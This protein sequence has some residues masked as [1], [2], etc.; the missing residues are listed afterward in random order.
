MTI[1]MSD[2]LTEIQFAVES[3]LAA[4]WADHDEAHHL[5]ATL[6]ALKAQTEAGYARAEAIAVNAEDPDDVAMSAG[7]HW[8]TYFGP[9]KDR[10]QA[11][12]GYDDVRARF[13]ARQFSLAAM[14]GAVLQHAKQAISM[15]HGG[16][17]ACPDGR[18]VSATQNL[19]PVIWQARNQASHWEEGNL[20]HPVV[21]CFNA[22]GAEVDSYFF[23]DLYTRS[24]AF[25]VLHL[26]GWRSWAAFH[27]DL[28]SLA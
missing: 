9:D 19:A 7:T 21:D 23:S 16:P 1:T 13:E 20:N 26:M 14:S 12:A 4:I 3:A 27:N 10:H 25:D 6:K 28:L 8:D 5:L 24:L 15:V 22:L 18:L 11:A 2:Y 17:K